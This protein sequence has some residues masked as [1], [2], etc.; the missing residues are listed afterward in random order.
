MSPETLIP[1]MAAQVNWKTDEHP[2]LDETLRNAA[3]NILQN[4]AF[5]T[6][7]TEAWKYTRTTK[8]KNGTFS[9]NKSSLTENTHA[10]TA[11]SIGN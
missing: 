1:E 10:S 6:T 8:L 9:A 7:K 5:P 11:N 4:T 3:L 2:I